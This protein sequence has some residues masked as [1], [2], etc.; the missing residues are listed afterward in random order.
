MGFG[1][2]VLPAPRGAVVADVPTASETPD[3]RRGWWRPGL[4]RPASGRRQP[5][6]ALGAIV[7]AVTLSAIAGETTPFTW[8]ADL[9]TA[10]A[11]VAGVIGVGLRIRSDRR[12]AAEP[13]APGPVPSAPPAH[14]RWPWL[15]VVVAVVA[16]ELVTY[17]AG[18]SGAAGREAYPT[19]SSLFDAATDGPAL[20]AL[21]F[22]LWLGLGWAV[23]AG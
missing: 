2:W 17:F 16:W 3:A 8:P 20:R 19:L 12:L 7:A 10:V 1:A 15:V 22:L 5:L 9:V 13:A 4:D 23:M 21:A 18:A 14:R 6:A 11:L